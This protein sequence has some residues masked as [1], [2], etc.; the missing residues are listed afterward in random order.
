[1][2]RIGQNALTCSASSHSA[3]MPL[4]RL[5]LTRRTP[6]RISWSVCARFST[7]R[8]LNRMSQ[9]ELRRQLLPELHG[10]LVDRGA[11]VP[12]VVGADD[13]RVARHIAAGQP[14]PLQ[15]G[16]VGDP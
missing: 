4:S 1:M 10:V 7:P 11:L 12:E 15:G 13:G 6:S 2:L 3:S 8:W 9:V 16:D 5:A 14:A